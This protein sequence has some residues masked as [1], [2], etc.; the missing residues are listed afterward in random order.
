[1][2]FDDPKAK[3]LE[4]PGTPDPIVQSVTFSF[5]PACLDGPVLG[6]ASSTRIEPPKADRRRPSTS[7]SPEL[8]RQGQEARRDRWWEVLDALEIGQTT[9]LNPR[10]A[11]FTTDL[12]RGTWGRDYKRVREVDQVALRPHPWEFLSVP[13]QS[14]FVPCRFGRRV[15]PFEGGLSL[16]LAARLQTL[17]KRKQPSW[18]TIP[19][20]RGQALETPADYLRLRPIVGDEA[21][22]PIRRTFEP[23]GVAR[24]PKT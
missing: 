4:F 13:R 15:S 23:L 1:M 10:A 2:Y 20:K 24:R 6:R 21:E 5:A 22:K 3:R 8:K 18:R 9:N 17:R 7:S 14:K 12:N 16:A 11:V 19:Y